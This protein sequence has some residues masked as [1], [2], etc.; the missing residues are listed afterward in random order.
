MGAEEVKAEAEAVQVGG[1]TAAVPGWGGL[2]IEQREVISRPA[3]ILTPVASVLGALVVGTIPLIALGVNP[4]DAYA[5][6]FGS[7]SSAS[8]YFSELLVKATPLIFTGL[9]VALPL[10]AGL[11]NIGGEGQLH[12]GA[13]AATGV[14]LM[15][16]N[17]EAGL[18]APVLLGVMALAGALAGGAWAFIP[19]FFKAKLGVNE[20]ITTL[21]MNIIAIFWVNY[22]VIG[23]WRD[24]FG[25]NF[26]LTEMFTQAGWL[27][28]FW[29]TRL[30]AGL[31]IAI[32]AAVLIYF[33]F[34]KTRFGYEIKMVGAN[35]TV[36]ELGGISKVKIILIIMVIGGALAALAGFG[37]VSGI[38]RRLRPGISPNYGFTGIVVALLGKGHPLGVILSAVFFGMLLI[39]GSSMQ[40]SSFDSIFAAGETVQVPVAIADIIQALVIFFIIGGEFL[41]RYRIRWRRS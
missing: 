26:P 32:A 17:T 21:L 31:F 39:G 14:A 11:W 24:P 22:L 28:R 37:E 8:F 4:L 18:P 35:P 16:I 6:L 3:Q 30:H 7:G 33:V 13:F 27:P 34:L 36:A 29:N 20:I 41:A 12:M 15:A 23:P 5:K 19:A 38:H 2:Q 40:L 25:F 9:A 10:K 1:A